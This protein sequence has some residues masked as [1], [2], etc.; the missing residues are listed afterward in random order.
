MSRTLNSLLGL[1]L[2]M[3]AFGCT[4]TVEK[5][6]YV[7]NDF[8][9]NKV[10]VA[11][12]GAS[13]IILLTDSA[14]LAGSGSDSD[15]R[16]VAYLWSQVS[17]PAA[18]TIVSPGSAS[19]AVKFTVKGNYMFQLMVTD[20]KGATGVDTVKVTVNQATN[21][22]LTLQPAN[23]PTEFTL[24]LLYGADG[25]GISLTSLEAFALAASGNTYNGQI[26]R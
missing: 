19:S 6:E 16:V 2:L 20:N 23:N 25:T 14:V 11:E 22:T 3:L 26:G 4:K 10:P 9:E 15:G 8:I 13:K 12:A 21:G 7:E 5:I 18:S 1:S 17:G 24:C